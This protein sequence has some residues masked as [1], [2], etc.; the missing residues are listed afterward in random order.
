VEDGLSRT[1]F[2]ASLA[3]TGEELVRFCEHVTVL[4]FQRAHLVERDM[5]ACFL[6]AY[7]VGPDGRVYAQRER[8][9]YAIEVFRPDG[10][11]ERVIEREY[12]SWK[13]D[14]RELDRMNALFEVQAKQLSFDITWEVETHEQAISGMHVAADNTLWVQHSRSGRDQSPGVLLTYDLF[15]SQGRYLQEVSIAC[16]GDPNYD[17]LIFLEDGRV[18]LVKG[19][20][21]ARMTSSGSQGAVYGDE[22]E[23]G[24]LEV[25]CCRMVE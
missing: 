9:E 12:E 10:T 15:D 18:L 14:K 11:L 8:N 19:L 3:E 1:S 7:A 20:V 4:D 23:T 6:G 25:I 22:E 17:G 16:E 24:P 21:L 2:L 13:R 5:L